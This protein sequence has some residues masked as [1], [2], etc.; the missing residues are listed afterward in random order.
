MCAFLLSFVVI[1]W[2]ML[3]CP[4]QQHFKKIICAVVSAVLLSGEHCLYA[5]LCLDDGGVAAVVFFTVA[6]TVTPLC[7]FTIY[8]LYLFRKNKK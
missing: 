3:T 8:Q 7:V 6:F 4:K 5:I 2:I 1:L